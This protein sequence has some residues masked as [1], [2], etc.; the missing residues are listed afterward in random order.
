MAKPELPEATGLGGQPSAGR[1]RF[2]HRLRA[3]PFP[4]PKY[5]SFVPELEDPL[6]HEAAV[7]LQVQALGIHIPEKG[8]NEEKGAFPPGTPYRGPQIH[9]SRMPVLAGRPGGTV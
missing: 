6:Q 2:P 1:Y 7:P 8:I 5:G 4:G 9:F 3:I